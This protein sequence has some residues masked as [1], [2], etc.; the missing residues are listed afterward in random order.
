MFNIAN[1]KEMQIKS[2]MRYRHTPVRMAVIK[3]TQI[4]NV[5]LDVK[6]MGLLYTVAG[7]VN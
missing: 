7:I 6:K 2:T 5:G 3:K 1:S 4:K